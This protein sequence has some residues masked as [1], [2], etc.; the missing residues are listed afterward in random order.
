MGL[1]FGEA[2]VEKGVQVVPVCVGWKMY[3]KASKG[4]PRI[5]GGVYGERLGHSRLKVV[6]VMGWKGCTERRE[7]G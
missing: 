3:W 5:Y 7:K 4:L 6:I 1:L 2:P